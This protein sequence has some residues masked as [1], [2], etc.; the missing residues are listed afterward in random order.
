VSG[1]GYYKVYR[2]TSPTG[3][4]ELIATVTGLHYDDESADRAFYYV[5]ALS[6]APARQ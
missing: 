1:A 5:E 2:N 6:G 3:I 4:F